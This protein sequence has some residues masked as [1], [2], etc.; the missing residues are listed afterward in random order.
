MPASNGFGKLDIEIADDQS[1]G[2]SIHRRISNIA[3]ISVGEE[4]VGYHHGISDRLH[5]GISGAGC[6]YRVDRVSLLSQQRREN[7]PG[8]RLV[9]NQQDSLFQT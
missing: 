9:L 2:A 6:G 5:A 1:F 4:P 7:F 3:A 8:G